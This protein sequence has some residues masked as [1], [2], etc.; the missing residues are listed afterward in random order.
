MAWHRRY[1][2]PVNSG[3]S[4]RITVLF[5]RKDLLWVPPQDQTI[6]PYTQEHVKIPM[7]A[8]DG[9]LVGPNIFD[10]M[11]K[12]QRD[13]K[14]LDKLGMENAAI[15]TYMVIR[16][17]KELFE[18][19]K[20][21]KVMK[22]APETEEEEGE[23]SARKEPLKKS[24]CTKGYRVSR[25]DDFYLVSKKS[26]VSISRLVFLLAS[27]MCGS[28]ENASTMIR[29]VAE[30][31]W[32]RDIK[33]AKKLYDLITSEEHGIHSGDIPQNLLA[34][35]TISQ[36]VETLILREAC[37]WMGVDPDE[38]ITRKRGR[39]YSG[40]ADLDEN[41]HAGSVLVLCLGDD[42]SVSGWLIADFGGHAKGTKLESLNLM[43]LA[44]LLVDLQDAEHT[45]DAELLEA[46]LEA[47]DPE[48]RDRIL[49]DAED[50]DTDAN[51]ALDPYTVLGVSPD[52]TLEEVTK[53]YRKAMRQVHPDKSGLPSFF[54]Q[55]V[56]EAYK[57]LK[58]QLL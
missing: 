40:G 47:I 20:K 39:P 9:R 38:V 15:G 37:G 46:Y 18:P 4:P 58:E 16:D 24:L 44:Q 52:A 27:G 13:K 32:D 53:A 42:E 45:L 28:P 10:V 30:A 22:L 19:P 11:K 31:A 17:A 14:Q 35:S 43:A 1:V 41:S 51:T 7:T 54:A 26:T 8:K 33:R 34:E 23:E 49:D 6:N 57:T 50:I 12:V 5:Y 2:A 3:A 36:E 48:W 25:E 29:D 55:T 56:I 21:P